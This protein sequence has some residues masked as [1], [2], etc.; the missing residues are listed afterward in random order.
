MPKKSPMQILDL[1]RDRVRQPS[2]LE[3]MAPVD[4]VLRVFIDQAEIAGA[5][6]HQVPGIG[7]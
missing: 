7:G 5:N 1:L 4:K 3:R 6:I 2:A